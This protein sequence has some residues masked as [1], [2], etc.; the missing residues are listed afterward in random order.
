MAKFKSIIDNGSS[1]YYLLHRPALVKTR[2]LQF[3]F[4]VVGHG[5]RGA[6]DLVCENNGGLPSGHKVKREIDF[7]NLPD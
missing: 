2:G 4:P 3:G 7:V 1:E 6:C 5:V